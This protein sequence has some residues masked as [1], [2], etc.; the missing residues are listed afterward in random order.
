MGPEE[1]QH[2]RDQ[3]LL[4]PGVTVVGLRDDAQLVVADVRRELQCVLRRDDL[5][6]GA[7]DRENPT[8]QENFS[9]YYYY[10]ING[11]CLYIQPCP[12][13]C[14]RCLTCSLCLWHGWRK[15]YQCSAGLPDSLSPPGTPAP[16]HN[17][18]NSSD[19]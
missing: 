11:R 4:V 7:V 14:K 19:E 10:S 1:A 12:C 15:G 2:Q 18:Q 17:H 13:V 6:F 8:H 5:V 9:S 3:L 16:L